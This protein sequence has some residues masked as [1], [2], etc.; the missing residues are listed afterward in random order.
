[1]MIAYPPADIVCEL[2]ESRI[3]SV[4]IENQI[5]F[6]NIITDIYEQIKG[7]DGIFVL[8]ENFTPL[9]IRKNADLISTLIPFEVNQ[10]EMINKLYTD[11]KNKA[12][13]ENSYQQT[14]ELFSAI[15]KY[16]FELSAITDNELSFD[17]PDD[18]SGILKMFNVRINDKDMALH[19]KL[20]EYML[21]AEKLKGT[22]VFITVNLRSY[23]TD[24][25]TELLFKSV[26]LHKIHM[27][28]IENK[29]YPRLDTE[30]VII[31]DKDMCLI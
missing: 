25:Q 31:I 27:I 9:D 19:E 21:A 1:M 30:K 29:E 15:S 23:I 12:V 11:L 4:V 26:L 5:M 8:S 2:D 17:F 3:M 13:D 28:C 10:K 6:R 24:E 18:I 20:L 16:L 7:H 14:Q 22:K